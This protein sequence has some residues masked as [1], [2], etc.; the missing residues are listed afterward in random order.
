M[1]IYAYDAT[2]VD[3][4]GQVRC[5]ELECEPLPVAG[6]SGSELEQTLRLGGSASQKSPGDSQIK[7]RV[8]RLIP[9][10][11]FRHPSLS[12]LPFAVPSGTAFSSH[13]RPSTCTHCRVGSLSR[14][15]GEFEFQT[16]SLGE[17]TM[18]SCHSTTGA[19][20]ASTADAYAGPPSRVCEIMGFD[21]GVFPLM[22][23]DASTATTS[24]DVKK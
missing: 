22:S 24:A 1:L 8:P 4:P 16:Y 19:V 21:Q 5:G 10:L 17:N 14:Q 13:P 6:H 11:G 9:S 15:L 20:T 23:Q 3:L 12:V 2:A 18:L 7:P